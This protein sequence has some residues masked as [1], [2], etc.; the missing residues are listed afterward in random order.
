M[1]LLY[2]DTSCLTHFRGVLGSDSVCDLDHNLC[3]RYKL[4]KKVMKWRPVL[5]TV[6]FTVYNSE[7]MICMQSGNME[8]GLAVLL[9]SFKDLKCMEFHC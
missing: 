8:T 5:D 9:V 1:F 7:S 3:H 6:H 4:H 2:L